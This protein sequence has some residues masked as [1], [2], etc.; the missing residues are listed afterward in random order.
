MQDC[1]TLST[2]FIWVR[3]TKTTMNTREKLT[4]EISPVVLFQACQMW[5]KQGNPITVDFQLFAWITTA[6]FLFKA[7]LET[8]NGDDYWTIIRQKQGE[9]WWINSPRRSRGEH[10]PMCTEPEANNW[11]SIIFRGEYQGLQSNGLQHKNTDAIVRAHTR[12]HP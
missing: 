3:V 1:N 7:S 6:F 4:V 10:S 5:T 9:H 12:M 11:F 2:W 8:S